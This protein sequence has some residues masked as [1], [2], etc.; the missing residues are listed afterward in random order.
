[1]GEEIFRADDER[2]RL[3]RQRRLLVVSFLVSVILLLSCMAAI[4]IVGSRSS[5]GAT[6]T[7]RVEAP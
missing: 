7:G 5:A 4:A 6:P 2:A 1:M 3:R